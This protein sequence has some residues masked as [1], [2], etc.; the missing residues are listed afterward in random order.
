MT[1]FVKLRAVLY[2]SL[3]TLFITCTILAFTSIGFPYSDAQHAPRLQRFRTTHI[4]RTV[5][6]PAGVEKSS[7]SNMMIYA[8]DRNGIR[9]LKE[10]FDGQEFLYMRNDEMCADYYLCGFQHRALDE[11]VI[12]LKGFHSSPNIQPTKYNLIKATNNAGIVDIEFA[13]EL[14]TT[15]QLSLTLDEGLEFE[16]SNIDFN[17]VIRNQK[18]HVVTTITVG[19]GNNESY[20]IKVQLRVNIIIF[21][22]NYLLID[23]FLSNFNRVHQLQ[24]YLHH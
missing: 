13:L 8:W 3:L 18:R 5:Y 1:L 7:I 21:Q 4:K 19:L 6:D 20:P 11:R 17:K 10:A 22:I 16:S 24:I 14:R 2:C 15:V 23:L 9:T 12:A